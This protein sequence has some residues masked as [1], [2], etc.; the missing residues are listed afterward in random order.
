MGN[1]LRFPLAVIAGLVLAVVTIGLVQSIG[2]QLFPL[3]PELDPHDRE[4]LKAYIANARIEVFLFVLL[5]YAIGSFLGG[6]VTAL[7][8]RPNSV[9]PCLVL[10]SILTAFGGMNLIL[11]PVHPL[12]FAIAMFG[13]FLPMTWLASR[14]VAVR[15]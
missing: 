8:T 13:C 1:A 10:G 7:I 6:V 3:P 2:H 5:A 12:W 11:L 4:Q 14:T 15:S 9:V